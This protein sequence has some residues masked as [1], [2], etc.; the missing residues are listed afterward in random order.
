[1]RGYVWLC[2]LLAWGC[3][4]NPIP[5]GTYTFETTTVTT[6]IGDDASCGRM[7]SPNDGYEGVFIVEKK[8]EGSVF[9]TEHPTG[10]KFEAEVRG[11]AFVA[12]DAE[13]L[14]LTFRYGDD[15]RALFNDFELD[16][17]RGTLRATKEFF[18]SVATGSGHGCA[19]IEGRLRDF[20][21]DAS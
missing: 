21:P 2:A 13:C 4:P 5:T 8:A 15:D 18:L 9:V 10:C 3:E 7:G 19:V 12:K 14:T 20:Q 11:R 1:M 16:S 6:A 17:E